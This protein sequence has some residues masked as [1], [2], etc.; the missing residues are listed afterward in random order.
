LPNLQ[1]DL[2]NALADP[3]NVEPDFYFVHL[4]ILSRCQ[5]RPTPGASRNLSPPW[6]KTKL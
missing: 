2:T 1:I 4:S 5:P 6:V 3:R